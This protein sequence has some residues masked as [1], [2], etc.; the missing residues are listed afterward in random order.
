[1]RATKNSRF[2]KGSGVF[3]C[4]S[5]KRSTRDT[6]GDNTSLRLCEEC[7]EL[8]GIE[9]QISDQGGTPELRAEVEKWKARCVAKGGR[10]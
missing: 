8:A 4:E 10:L 3:Q 7:Y 5:C 9:N 1:M 6:G 2:Q